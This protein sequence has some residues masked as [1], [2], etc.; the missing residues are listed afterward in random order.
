MSRILLLAY[1]FAVSTRLADAQSPPEGDRTEP[2]GS[3]GP[4][5]PEG[6]AAKAGA[7]V[8]PQAAGTE[9]AFILADIRG[10]PASWLAGDPEGCPAF[11][12]LARDGLAIVSLIGGTEGPDEFL[13]SLVGA[14]E[15][16]LFRKAG[17]KHAAERMW[18][19]SPHAGRSAVD[20][21]GG[22]QLFAPDLRLPAFW[23]LA[24]RYGTSPPLDEGDLAALRTLRRRY[25]AEPTPFEEG[26]VI[27]TFSGIAPG[28]DAIVLDRMARLIRSRNASL[29]LAVL[30]GPET[31]GEADA[32]RKA[33]RETD[34]ALGRLRSLLGEEPYRNRTLFAY[35]SLAGRDIAGGPPG[36]PSPAGGCG[37][38]I[39]P[40]LRKGSVLQ[41]AAGLVAVRDL[42][43]RCLDL[44]GDGVSP[45]IPAEVR[46]P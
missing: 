41:D 27:M 21:A 30:R 45:A 32:A 39:A 35:L 6:G 20:L 18:L 34:A 10:I 44:E 12:D 8:G 19:L 43:L 31:A 7:E 3:E 28:S 46:K 25:S 40:A 36:R 14:G 42:L 33:V 24:G 38:V 29:V 26:L 13:R 4:A 5:Q 2:K 22:A 37:V 16:N 17:K 1:L 11:R 23:G 9:F 15:K